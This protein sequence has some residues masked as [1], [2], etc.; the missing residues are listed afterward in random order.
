M[1]K[2]SAAA[3]QTKLARRSKDA[4]RLLEEATIIVGDIFG[5]QPECIEAAAL[6][7]GIARALGSTVTPRAVSTVAFSPISGSVVA[8]GSRAAAWVEEQYRLRG[9]NASW[10]HSAGSPELDAHEFLRA[11]HMVVTLDEPAMVFDPTFRQF[12]RNGLPMTSIAANIPSTHP[13]DCK[14]QLKVATLGLFVTYF[15]EDENRG[16]Q[17]TFDTRVEGWDFTA[18]QIATGLRAGY[19]ARGF[20]THLRLEPPAY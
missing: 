11:G 16:W 3:H 5:T 9:E 1:S 19:G 8:T 10:R 15:I 13:D 18:R 2:R 12:S 20:P 14:W 6:M 7:V 17:D 4:A